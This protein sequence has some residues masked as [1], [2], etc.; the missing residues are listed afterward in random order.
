MIRPEPQAATAVL[1]N[2]VLDDPCR[3]CQQQPVILDHQGRA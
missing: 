1:D 2:D 3:L